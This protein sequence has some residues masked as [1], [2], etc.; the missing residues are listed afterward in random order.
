M[1]D[2]RSVTGNTQDETDQKVKKLSKIVE[3]PVKRTEE[4]KRTQASH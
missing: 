3:S 1:V 4:P 2:L